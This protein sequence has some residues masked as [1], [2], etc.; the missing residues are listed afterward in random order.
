MGWHWIVGDGKNWHW[1]VGDGMGWN[2][3]VGDG[4]GGMSM[5]NIEWFIRYS[6][7]RKPP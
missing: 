2:W 6:N 4:M 7:L 1:T 3:V 5:K